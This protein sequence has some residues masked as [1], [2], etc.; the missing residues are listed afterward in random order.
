MGKE[1]SGSIT[2]RQDEVS[3]KEKKFP[4]GQKEENVGIAR[5]ARGSM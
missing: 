5:R 1:L 3:T 4:S 2:Y